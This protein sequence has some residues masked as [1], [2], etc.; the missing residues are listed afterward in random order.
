[1]IPCAA[2]VVGGLVV[3]GGEGCILRLTIRFLEGMVEVVEE[4]GWE[5]MEAERRLGRGMILW[6][7]A[8][9]RRICEVE[10][11]S[12][13]VEEWGGGRRIRLAGLGAGISSDEESRD[14]FVYEEMKMHYSGGEAT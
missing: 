5:G 3:S 6:D 2:L 8:M 11:G 10:G 4:E 1:M 12:L 13:V 9:G 7:R 14:W